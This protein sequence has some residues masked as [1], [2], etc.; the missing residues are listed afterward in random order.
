[1]LAKY[2]VGI[3]PQT[4]EHHSIHKED[5]P[6]LPVTGKRI[7]LGIFRSPYDAVNEGKRHFYKSENCLFCSKEHHTKETEHALYELSVS[8]DLISADRL[9]DI[10]ENAFQCSVN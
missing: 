7:Y 2:Y 4:N 10:W 1:M 3:R 8:R 5:C 6:F 9:K